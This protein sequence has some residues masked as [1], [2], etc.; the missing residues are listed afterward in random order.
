VFVGRP[1]NYAASVGGEAGVFHAIDLLRSEVDRNLAMLGIDR[2]SGI[3]QSI[4]R[5]VTAEPFE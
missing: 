5:H 3:D 1:F 4:L 2:I